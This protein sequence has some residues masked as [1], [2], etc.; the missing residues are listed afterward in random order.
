[1]KNEDE[2]KFP[3]GRIKKVFFRICAITSGVNTKVVYSK[4]H[5]RV[6]VCKV[7]YLEPK[8]PGGGVLPTSDRVD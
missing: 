7:S 2:I 3:D 6:A 5:A 8:P 4:G 1:M